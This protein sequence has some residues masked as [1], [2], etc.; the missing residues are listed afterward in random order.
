MILTN[1]KK[2]QKILPN[3]QNSKTTNFLDY[4][5]NQSVKKKVDKFIQD[6]N[7]DCESTR[8]ITYKS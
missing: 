8:N 4:K 1:A 2:S 7:Y 5:N 3:I 6:I